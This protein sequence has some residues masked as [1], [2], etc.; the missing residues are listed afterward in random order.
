MPTHEARKLRSLAT[1]II[2]AFLVLVLAGE[3]YWNAVH[4]AASEEDRL[5][6]RALVLEGRRERD[7]LAAAV[8]ALRAEVALIRTKVDDRGSHQ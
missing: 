7:G 4:H 5:E 1:A 3:T 6:I 2:L 8:A